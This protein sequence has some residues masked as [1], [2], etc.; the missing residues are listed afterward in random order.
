M[1]IYKHEPGD[2]APSEALLKHLDLNPIISEK[3]FKVTYASLAESQHF[4]EA[5]AQHL[6]L[7]DEADYTDIAEEFLNSVE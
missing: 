4:R 6:G 2:A 5:L 7:A 1:N 3:P